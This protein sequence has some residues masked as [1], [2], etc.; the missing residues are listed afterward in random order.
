MD[1]SERTELLDKVLA[2]ISDECVDIGG[3]N[4]CRYDDVVKKIERLKD[5]HLTLK[6]GDGSISLTMQTVL[7]QSTVVIP[8]H[9]LKDVIRAM[10]NR[11]KAMEEQGRL[12]KAGYWKE[13][14]EYES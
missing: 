4:M 1:K 8:Q 11:L 13:V 5:G 10:S 6:V 3:H 7:A 14:A 2:I 12:V 9:V